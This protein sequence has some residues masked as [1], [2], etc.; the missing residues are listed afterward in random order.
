[1]RQTNSQPENQGLIRN[2]LAA[3]VV[4]FTS[5]A[6]MLLLV[7]AIAHLRT[8]AVLGEY[9]FL[10]L[11]VQLAE[12]LKCMGLNTLV[13][14]EAAKFPSDSLRWWKSLV[15]VGNWGCLF[16]AP[17]LLIAVVISSHGIL[18]PDSFL[19][20][21][22][23][24]PGLW[25][26]SYTVSN[27]A[28]F[29]G[30]GR[31]SDLAIVTAIESFARAILSVSALY[32]LHVSIVGLI[33]IYSL[34]RVLSALAGGVLRRRLH[35]QHAAYNK[36]LTRTILKESIPFV[37]VF[38]V[39]LVLFRMDILALGLAATA[40]EVGT[41]SAASRLFT[42]A[43]LLPDAAMSTLFASYSHA[44]VAGKDRF[45]SLVI[46]S[47]NVIVS[48]AT[49]MGGVAYLAGPFVIEVLF[50]RQF[51]ESAPIFRILIWALPL[52]AFSRSFGD[53]LVALGR[54]SITATL[55]ACTTIVSIGVYAVLVPRLHGM[56]AAQGFLSSAI[57]LAILTGIAFWQIQGIE[58]YKIAFQLF[59]VVAAILATTL[60]VSPFIRT[61]IM[62]AVILTTV[63]LVL[64]MII[65][66]R[67]DM[68]TPQP[69]EAER[70]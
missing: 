52:F 49:L 31:V 12:L 36:E 53:A 13:Q 34:T 65:N 54:Q 45:Q 24:L 58:F 38:V 26:S 63:A 22:V 15:R 70:S 68:E 29:F 28:L 17:L 9:T 44:T 21:F 7:V 67:I 61:A 55:V 42:L 20:C 37:T 39:P 46:T 2:T 47:S 3:I 59:P 51:G 14:R 4:K 23:L 8:P 64:K 35:L 41:Y 50:G 66:K 48:V 40:S 10:V 60:P 27:E 43:L 1:M 6:S 30:L 69:A 57:I 19:T 32:L 5:P 16:A 11:L 62:V 56:G 25:A 18:S 33:C